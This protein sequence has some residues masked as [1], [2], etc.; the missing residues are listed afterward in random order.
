MSGIG[1]VSFPASQDSDAGGLLSSLQEQ[2]DR[3]SRTSEPRFSP[4]EFSPYD[5]GRSTLLEDMFKL[6]RNLERSIARLRR[7]SFDS[8]VSS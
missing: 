3:M 8:T 5:Q 7:S 1:I 6:Q 4:S 2:L